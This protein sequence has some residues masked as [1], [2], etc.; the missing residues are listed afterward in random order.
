MIKRALVLGLLAM[1]L[2]GCVER[3]LTIESTPPGALVWLND[4]EIGRTPLT[5][6]FTWYGNYDVQLRKEGYETVKTNMMMKAPWWQWVP[7]DLVAELFP[8]TDRQHFTFSMLRAT[9]QPV[10]PNAILQ[11][12]SNMQGGLESGVNT[13]RPATPTTRKIK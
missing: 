3:K 13:K 2:G 8:V 1:S 12:A 4:Q 11:R 7:I 9:T 5:R 6:D 10:D